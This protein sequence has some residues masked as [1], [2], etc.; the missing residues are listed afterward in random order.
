MAEVER[1]RT[2]DMARK[3][4]SFLFFSIFVLLS[5]FFFFLKIL[6]W[7]VILLE[8]WALGDGNEMDDWC[9]YKIIFF[10]IKE[11]VREGN[12]N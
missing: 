10:S 7:V 3:V 12:Q 9:R 2:A 8:I 1:P 5:F 6:W 4:R 11:K